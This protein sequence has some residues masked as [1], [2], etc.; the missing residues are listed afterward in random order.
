ME[1]KCAA[2]E[3]TALAAQARRAPGYPRFV[4][5][6]V[7]LIRGFERQIVQEVKAQFDI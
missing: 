7:S 2:R 3:T 1:K 5:A 6:T 4:V